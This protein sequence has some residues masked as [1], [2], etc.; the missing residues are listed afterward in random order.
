MLLGLA[1]LGITNAFALLGYCQ[2]ATVTKDAEILA[3]RHQ[4]AVLH[5]R[6]GGQRVRFEPVDRARTGPGLPSKF[7]LPRR[8]SCPKVAS[9]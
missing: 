7:R 1:C 2:A 8:A 3:R 4:L 6:P 9:K 5:R